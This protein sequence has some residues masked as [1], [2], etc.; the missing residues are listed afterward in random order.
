MADQLSEQ[1]FND[2]FNRVMASAPDGLDEASFNA[3][4][5]QEV[6]K[7]EGTPRHR[8]KP[9]KAPEIANSPLMQRLV[10]GAE[11]GGLMTA[12][13]GMAAEGGKFLQGV[14]RRL[15]GGLLKPKQGLKDSFGDATEIAGTLLKERAPISKGGVAKMTGR[16]ADSRGK[17]MGMVKAADDAGMQ[18][19]VAKDVVSEFAPVV[20]ELR[21]R[22]DI[23]QADEL[24]K[25]GQRGKRILSTVHRS[26][27]GGE[28]PLTRAQALKETA[29]D[30]S[31]GAYR[32][33]ERGTQKQLSADDMLD[34]AVAR[35]LK[36]GIERRVPGVQAQNARTQSLIGGKNALEDAVERESNNLLGGGMRDIGALVAGIGGTAVG[37]P[38]L[39]IP[40]AAI[41]RGMATQAIGSRAAIGL[42][43]ASKMGLDDALQRALLVALSQGS[44]QQ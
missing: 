10:E 29:Q 40:A 13:P 12:A 42:N 7:A 9:S 34:T 21:K 43:E 38:S 2:V 1:Q 30:A 8:Q 44:H 27:T 41:M 37:G 18:G 11:G 39:G 26:P 19:V 16:L 3:L 25:V 28:I 35:G 32:A 33:M 23:G 22:V 17:A 20:K 36:Q 4:L 14:A 5:D 6:A 15:Y 31:S 24:G